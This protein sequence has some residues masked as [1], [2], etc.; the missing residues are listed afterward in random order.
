MCDERPEWTGWEDATG[1][2]GV[3]SENENGWMESGRLLS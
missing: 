3:P 1:V 2:F